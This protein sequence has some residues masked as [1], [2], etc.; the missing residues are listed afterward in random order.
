MPSAKHQLQDERE[1][2]AQMA[3]G[4]VQAF[5]KILNHYNKIIYQIILRMVKTEEAAEEVVQDV[6]LKLWQ[7]RTTFTDIEN[8][9]AFLFRMA[10]NRTLDA[11][12]KLSREKAMLIRLQQNLKH[13]K[14]NNTSELLDFK[15]SEGLVNRAVEQLPS[16]R[17][18]IYKMSRYAGLS[19]KEIAERLNI[20]PNTV[21]NQLIEA[22]KFIRS[23]LKK[24]AG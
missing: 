21:R 15:E 14:E 16:Q 10:S 6:F 7:N 12:K 9:R 20:S 2:F 19:H 23:F 3:T 22:L 13:Q 4:D 17:Q 18:I 11:L 5:T 8:H 1:L 24:M